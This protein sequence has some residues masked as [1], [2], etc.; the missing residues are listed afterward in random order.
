MFRS[1]FGLARIKKR[2]GANYWTSGQNFMVTNRLAQR[3]HLMKLDGFFT[4]DVQADHVRAK[5]EEKEE[6][7][8]IW[9]SLPVTWPTS[10]LPND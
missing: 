7:E 2:R 1:R 4:R 6:D 3:L 9:L 10:S 8:V 5:T